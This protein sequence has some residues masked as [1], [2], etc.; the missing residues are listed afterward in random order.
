MVNSKDERLHAGYTL[1]VCILTDMSTIV[2]HMQAVTLLVNYRSAI[3]GSTLHI[4]LICLVLVPTRV[5]RM[6]HSTSSAIRTLRPP[7]LQSG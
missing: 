7:P 3:T 1:L 2:S 6:L 4:L 5:V